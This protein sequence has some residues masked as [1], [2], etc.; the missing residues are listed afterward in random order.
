MFNTQAVILFLVG[1]AV[2]GF[3][4]DQQRKRR[5]MPDNEELELIRFEDLPSRIGAL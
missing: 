4:L 3:F 2:V 1:A 5:M